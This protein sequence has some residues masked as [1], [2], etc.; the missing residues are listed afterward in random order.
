MVNPVEKDI[1]ARKNE[2]ITEIRAVFKANMKITSWDVPEADDQL[3]GELIV[4][5]MQEALDKLKEELQE[6]NFSN[7]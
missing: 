5:I 7:S 6:G 4:N 2:I 3:A 1:L